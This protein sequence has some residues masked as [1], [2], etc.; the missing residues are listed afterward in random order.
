MLTCI[1]ARLCVLVAMG[2]DVDVNIAH[3]NWKDE[4][5]DFIDNKVDDLQNTVDTLRNLQINNYLSEDTQRLY[6]EVNE[7]A[8]PM[9]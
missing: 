7:K 5:K 3:L 4:S 2:L 1:W 6:G 8:R 9:R